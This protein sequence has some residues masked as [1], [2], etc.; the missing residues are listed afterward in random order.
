MTSLRA[1]AFFGVAVLQGMTAVAVAASPPSGGNCP[2]TDVS[3][4]HAVAPAY[5]TAAM[6][7][8][9]SPIAVQ[10]IVMV[11]A[12]GSVKSAAIAQSSGYTQPDANALQAAQASTYKP[13]TVDCKPVEGLYVFRA[14]FAPPT[15]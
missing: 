13:K 12:D 7:F 14:D 15:P 6:R 1:L 10:V 9:Q 2:A 5:P 3:V 11:A 8:V 4:A